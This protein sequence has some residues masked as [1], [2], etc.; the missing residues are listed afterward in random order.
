MSRTIRIVVVLVVVFLAYLGWR[1][2]AG[3]PTYARDVAPIIAT[4]CAACHRPGQA[5]PFSL[6]TYDD[7]KSRANLIVDVT[8]RGLM[9]P[10]PPVAGHG[11]FVG[12]RRLTPEQVAGL[13][14]WAAAGCPP[15]DLNAVPA[16][17]DEVDPWVAR[18]PD[19][20]LESPAYSLD[21]VDRDVFRNFVLTVP[22]ESPRWVE[23]I[24][25]RPTNLRVTHHAR[26][27]VDNSNESRRRD[28]EDAAPG[29][30]GMAWGQDPDGQLVIW[31]P[32]MTGAAP[33]TGSAWR[34]TPQSTLVLHAHLQPS[35]RPES[36]SFRVGIRFAKGPPERHPAI[37]RVGSCDIDIPAGVTRHVVEDD[38]TCPVDLD[39]YSI[40]PHA[41]SLC[42][43]LAVTAI[44]P[45][46]KSEPLVRID[47]FDEAWHDSYRFVRPVR[48]PRGTRI[49]STFTYDNSDGN[50]RNR[51]RPARRVA[52]GSNVVD[53][54][55]DVYLQVL[56][57]RADERAA[58]MED[59]KRYEL[60]A[61][62]IGYQRALSVHPDDP[63][64]RE[65]LA[66]CWF[67]LGE[68]KKGLAILES[69][70]RTGKPSVF[71]QT[72]L[73]LALLATGDAS[74]AEA[75]LREAL[76]FDKE[77]P[78]ASL[79]LGRALL[80]QKKAEPAEAAM[81]TAVRLAPEMP[82]ARQLLADLLIQ[83]GRLD[84]ADG[85]IAAA[86][87]ESADPAGLYLKRAEISARK[88][89][90][91]QCLEHCVAARRHA[92]YLHPPKVLA[93]ALVQSAGDGDRALTWLREAYAE[94]PGHPVPA[95]MLGQ[96]AR[97][98][99]QLPDA[100]NLLET[101][102]A[103]VPPANWPASHRKRFLILLHSE[104]LQLAQ[105][106]QDRA[107]AQDALHQWQLADPDNA[108]VRKW[109]AE[110]K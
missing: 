35:G 26:L 52:Y 28:A 71:T 32:G 11:D 65:G 7:V 36:V 29:F 109:L 21:A 66:A 5:A 96:L 83:S 4:Q 13:T 8:G 59:Y 48:L 3:T 78:L 61:Q 19:M 97:Q 40:F 101:S 22:L 46:G 74:A 94:N 39:V 76:A 24:E 69:L 43:S 50:P 93:A 107:L 9:P 103:K 62:A 25:L 57:V 64:S 79:G 108:Q 104:R 55:A 51:Q 41:H 85:L 82:E 87:A 16:V 102:A 70:V 33:I 6:L 89:Q 17:A 100:R 18:P 60:K 23:S 30:A 95:L 90:A 20:I 15:G 44:R 56:P 88:R 27:G 2:M 14:R 34:L 86:V 77:Y 81:R 10:W 37:L 72:S 47:R 1:R 12:E 58:L 98:R 42:Q 80:A 49:H 99:R 110:L 67:G 105:Q 92:P 68:P 31:A 38:F 75:R 73:G 91:D 53:E 45:D 63:W 84:E 54:M 106:L